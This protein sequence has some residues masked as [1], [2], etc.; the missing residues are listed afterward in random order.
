MKEGCIEEE[1]C[2]LHLEAD[3]TRYQNGEIR[4]GIGRKILWM[5]IGI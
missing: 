1:V 4:H 5:G 2:E 3:F